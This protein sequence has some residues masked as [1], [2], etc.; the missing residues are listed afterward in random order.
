MIRVEEE[1]FAAYAGD[2]VKLRLKGVEEE[3]SKSICIAKPYHTH[4]YVLSLLLFF[5]SEFMVSP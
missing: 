5:N 4:L 2:N 3:V 1:V